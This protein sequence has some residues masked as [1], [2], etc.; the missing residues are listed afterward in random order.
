[1]RDLGLMI[2]MSTLSQF[3]WR[4]LDC[5]QDYFSDAVVESALSGNG[6]GFGE[7]VEYEVIGI[8]VEAETMNAYDVAKG[9]HVENEEEQDKRRTLGD[10]L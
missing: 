2:T 8:T 1:M 4:K 6:D 5:I 9:K 7:D 10:V 3:N